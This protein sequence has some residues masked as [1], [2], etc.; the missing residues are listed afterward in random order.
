[1]VEDYEDS[2]E[3]LKFLL[4][5]YGFH[6]LEASNG[7][8][9][10]EKVNEQVP[11]LILMD[12]SMPVMDGLTAAKKIRERKELKGLPIIAITAHGDTFYNKAIES[13][14]DH[15]INK[16]LDFESLEPVLS[17]YLKN[18]NGSSEH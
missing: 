1:M 15:L 13:G 17:L 18:G 3:F 6:V 2:R 7:Y 5:D 8:E 14:C 12:L 9:A 11:D 4:E 10:L 16:P